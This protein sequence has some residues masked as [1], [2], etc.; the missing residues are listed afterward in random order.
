MALGSAW[1]WGL[2]AEPQELRRLEPSASATSDQEFLAFI[3]R[4]K[5]IS[6]RKDAKSLLSLIGPVFRV[7]FDFGKGPAAFSKRWRPQDPSSELWRVLDRM[8]ALPAKRYDETLYVVPYVYGSFPID[9][10]PLSHVVT[11]GEAAAIRDAADSTAKELGRFGHAIIPT[12]ERLTVPVRLDRQ[13]WLKVAP[14]AGIVGY[15]SSS[16]VYSPAE[17]RGFFEKQ[18]GKWRWLSLVCAD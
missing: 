18:R 17:Y 4:I 8:L 11:I 5:D 1:S 9:L 7:D 14:S 16:D 2:P 10:D 15:V 3:G 12:A 13:E 6:A